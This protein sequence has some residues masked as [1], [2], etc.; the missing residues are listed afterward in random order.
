MTGRPFFRLLKSWSLR[1]LT[2][3]VVELSKLSAQFGAITEV[4]E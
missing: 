3:T 4:G 2:A 1:L